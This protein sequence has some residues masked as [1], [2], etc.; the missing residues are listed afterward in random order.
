LSSLNRGKRGRPFEFPDQFITFGA[1][2]HFLFNLRYRQL[3]GFFRGLSKFIHISA[4]H[5]TTLQK[6]ICKLNMDLKDSLV[7]NTEPI[8]I[9][10]VS[11]GVK[12]SNRG[13]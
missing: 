1:M 7:N 12:V 9:T 13:E 11:S 6:R 2:I 3:Q 8:I 5:F 10:V 4:P